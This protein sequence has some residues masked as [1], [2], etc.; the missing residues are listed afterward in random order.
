[1][2][3]LSIT[4]RITVTIGGLTR[5]YLAY[6]TTAPAELDLPRTVT[7]EEGPFEEVI[8]LAADPVA[9]DAARTCMPARVVLVES[10][11]RAWQRATYRGN[12]HLFLEADRWLVSVEKLESSLWQRLERRVAKPLVSA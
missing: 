8:G 4:P 3:H 7:V 1:M 2:F 10:G 11:E 6:V 12:H 9:V 5:L